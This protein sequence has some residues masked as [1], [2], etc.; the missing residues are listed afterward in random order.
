M[1]IFLSSTAFVSLYEKNVRKYAKVSASSHVQH[2][3]EGKTNKKYAEEK[4][5]TEKVCLHS[6]KNRVKTLI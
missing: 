6:A 5:R 3:Q 1:M 2:H 4:V